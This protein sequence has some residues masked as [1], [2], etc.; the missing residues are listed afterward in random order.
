MI[1]ENTEQVKAILKTKWI[2]FKNAAKHLGVDYE[3]LTKTVNGYEG[4]R[5]VTTALSKAGIPLVIQQTRNEAS[6]TRQPRKQQLKN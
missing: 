2:T 4:Y 3:Y 5:S 1:L 6:G